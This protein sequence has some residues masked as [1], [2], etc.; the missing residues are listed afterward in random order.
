MAALEP[1]CVK[2]KHFFR[3]LFYP[4]LDLHTRNRAVLSRFWKSGR[5]DVLN[6]GEVSKIK[7]NS[8][9]VGLRDMR[10]DGE[11]SDYSS[12]AS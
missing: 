10:E 1:V 12:L 7:A 6:P 2:A 11:M 4:G 9:L 8:R 3:A 5:R